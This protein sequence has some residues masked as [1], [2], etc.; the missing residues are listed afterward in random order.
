M[1][2]SARPVSPA[3]PASPGAASPAARRRREL[4]LLSSDDGLLIEIGPVLGDAYRSRPIDAPEQLDPTPGSAWMLVVD[5]TTRADARAVVARIEQQH[6]L[7]PIIVICAN[8]KAGDW[9]A[10]RSRGSIGVVID[11]SS[12][13]GRM[14]SAGVVSRP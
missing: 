7:A 5:A 3:D 4:Y 9:A 2:T 1:A 11:G 8:G 6:A 10:Q 13:C 14:I 12:I